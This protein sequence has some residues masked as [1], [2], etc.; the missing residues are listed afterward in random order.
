M[1]A[2]YAIANVQVFTGETLTAER[3]VC[4]MLEAS[5]FLERLVMP[6]ATGVL[7]VLHTPERSTV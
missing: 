1:H 2:V 6:Q 3:P 4:Q 7:T 5:G